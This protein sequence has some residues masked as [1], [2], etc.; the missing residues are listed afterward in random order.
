M[1]AFKKPEPITGETY[2]RYFLRLIEAFEAW[3]NARHADGETK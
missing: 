1:V 2:D 3:V